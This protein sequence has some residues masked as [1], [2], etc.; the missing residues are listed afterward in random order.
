MKLAPVFAKVLNKTK[1]TV[2][3]KS[4]MKEF[5]DKLTDVT[6]PIAKLYGAKPMLCG[7]VTKNTW[8]REKREA[9]LF[10]LFSP[11]INKKNLSDQGLRIS[12]EVISQLKGKY[13]IA[14]AEH[15]YL[16][17]MVKYKGKDYQVDIVPAY[18]VKDAGKIKSAVDR[19]PHHVKFIKENLRVPD[20]VRLLKQFLKSIKVYGA[21]VKTQGFSGYLSELLI[22]NYGNM[23]NLIKNV[24]KWRAPIALDLKKKA[25]RQKMHEKFKTPLIFIDP[26]DANRNVAAA[27]SEESFYRFVKGCNDFIKK[28]SP[29]F[30][31]QD[32]P[33]PYSI[34][35][36]QKEIKKRGTRWYLIKFD[37]PDVIDD[38]LYPQLRRCA[39]S[40]EK[41]LTAGG[42]RVFRKG[43]WVGNQIVLAFEMDIW[44]VP[45]M[46]KHIGPNVYSKHAED[47]LKHY[48][49][50]KIFIEN[51]NWILEKERDFIT[52]M[53]LL[54]DLVGKSKK[55]L[56]EKGIPSKIVD[57]FR[58]SSLA[59]G[60]DAVKMVR[61]LPEDFRVFLR[62]WFEEDFSII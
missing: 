15:P 38:I 51:K 1:P 10:L 39:N 9:D 22:I 49:K 36:V 13:E 62:N 54:K 29:N 48:D 41:I 59:S 12:K 30:F 52:V 55:K 8:I 31:F 34:N 11:G 7:S 6:T 47:F 25:N 4:E 61:A 57:N 21:D 23:S 27:V 5:I 18:S 46:A 53:H 60:G 28:P 43:F 37:K 3:E 26:V 32:H 17:G 56:S 14:Y 44:L 42:F 16:R 33:K 2:A 24:A 45:K 35:D 19:T 40:I 20:E 58:K 50:Y